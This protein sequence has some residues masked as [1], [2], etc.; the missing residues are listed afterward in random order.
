MLSRHSEKYGPIF[1]NNVRLICGELDNYYL[2][3]AVSL[4]KEEIDKQDLPAGPGY[5]KLIPKAD[6]GG[7]LMM[8]PAMRAVPGEMVKHLDR[9]R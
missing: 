2:N 3:E 9:Q 6:H 4:L 8:S 1:A 5:V 7:S